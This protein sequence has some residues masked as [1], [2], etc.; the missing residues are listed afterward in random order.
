MIRYKSDL[1]D[2]NEKWVEYLIELGNTYVCI[3]PIS[4]RP[5]SLVRTQYMHHQ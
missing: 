2:Q 4:H 5:N 3:C 1:N